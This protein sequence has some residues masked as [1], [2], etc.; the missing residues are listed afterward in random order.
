MWAGSWAAPLPPPSG[1]AITGLGAAWGHRPRCQGRSPLPIQPGAHPGGCLCH[2][3]SPCH[4]PRLPSGLPWGAPCWDPASVPASPPGLRRWGQSQGVCVP[5]PMACQEGLQPWHSP[6]TAAWRRRDRHR[7]RA[8]PSPPAAPCEGQI[9]GSPPRSFPRSQIQPGAACQGWNLPPHSLPTPLCAPYQEPAPAPG[10]AQEGAAPFSH[11]DQAPLRD[12]AARLQ[13]QLLGPEDPRL[14]LPRDGEVRGQ[15]ATPGP[16]RPHGHSPART[17]RSARGSGGSVREASASGEAGEDLGSQ[18]TPAP[19]GHGVG[20]VGDVGTPPPA[21]GVP[22]GECT[23]AEVFPR[24]LEPTQNTPKSPL[25]AAQ[26]ASAAACG[27]KRGHYCCL[28]TLGHGTAVTV[29]QEG[30][31]TA[32]PRLPAPCRAAGRGWGTPSGSKD[33]LRSRGPPA[34]GTLTA[35]CAAPAAPYVEVEETRGSGGAGR[36]GGAGVPRGTSRTLR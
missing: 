18:S 20:G 33:R 24:G 23:Q 29:P 1:P 17:R 31:G 13:H 34:P 27:C 35:A 16:P 11:V 26:A 10:G 30:T 22:Y 25:P 19:R 2:L 15:A 3:R 8:T 32:M 9:M 21:L 5:P 4:R 28:G 36:A 6:G 12:G 7:Q 14:A